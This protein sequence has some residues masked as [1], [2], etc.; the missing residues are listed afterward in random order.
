MPVRMNT[1]WCPIYGYSVPS[2]HACNNVCARR[3]QDTR[4]DSG[5]V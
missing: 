2:G 5:E 1:P 3:A 4:A